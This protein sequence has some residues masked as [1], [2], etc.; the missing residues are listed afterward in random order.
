MVLTREELASKLLTI[1]ESSVRDGAAELLLKAK[2][3]D[4]NAIEQLK[5][6]LERL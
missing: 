5:I 4:A 1:H 3:L 2:Q 6:C